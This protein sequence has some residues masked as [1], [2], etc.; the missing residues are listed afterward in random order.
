MLLFPIL[1]LIVFNIGVGFILSAMFV[2]FKDIQYL[3]DIF[4]LLLMYLSAIFYPVDSFSTTVQHLFYVNPMF[5]YISYIRSIV[6]HN[7]IPPLWHH[8][9][10]L[11][12]ALLAI[13][14]GALIYKRNNYKFLYYM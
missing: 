10:C 11:L 4:T 3:Y 6:L 1:C 9:L 14:I 12:Y 13:S 5:T 2:I 7:T 8:G